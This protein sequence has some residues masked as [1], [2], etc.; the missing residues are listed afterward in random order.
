M[1]SASI[2]ESG[3]LT[4]FARKDILD[5]LCRLDRAILLY[6][7]SSFYS[8]PSG[9]L[10]VTLSG[11]THVMTVK[12]GNRKE[13]L[14][15]RYVRGDACINLPDYWGDYYLSNAEYAIHRRSY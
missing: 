15:Y 3:R 5:E 9:S 13:P 6:F 11:D 7:P 10:R 8:G 1:S 14:E 4:S 12:L 2:I